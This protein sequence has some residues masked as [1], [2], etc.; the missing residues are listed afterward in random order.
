M[1]NAYVGCSESNAFLFIS[2]EPTVDTKSTVMP[3]VRAFFSCKTLIFIIATYVSYAFLTAMSKSL[4][5]V[6]VTVCTSRVYPLP[7][8]LKCTTRRL[9]VLASTVWSL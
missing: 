8:L 6:L 1:E 4:H 9:A 3:F 7:P 5:A 2:M